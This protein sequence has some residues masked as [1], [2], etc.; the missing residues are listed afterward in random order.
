M[1]GHDFRAEHLH[2]IHVEHLAFAIHRAHVNDA[3]HPEHRADRRGRHAVL[4]CTGLGDDARL[5]HALGEEDLAHGVVDLMRAGVVQVFALEINLR[6]AEFFREAFGKIKRR[7][8]PDEFGEIVGKFFLE[9]G[10]VLRAEIFFFQLLQRMH[11]RLGHVT[12][13]ERPKMAGGVG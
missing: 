11:Q 3:F 8:T 10:I 12:S 1:N 5:A 7:G 6:A 13:A 4:A 9:F 2:A